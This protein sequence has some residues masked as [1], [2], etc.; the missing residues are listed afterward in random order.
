MKLDDVFA[1]GGNAFGDV[2]AAVQQ[3]EI[4]QIISFALSTVT[5][6]IIIAF[7]IWA[8]WKKAKA[9]G[10]ISKEEIDE[11]HDIIDESRKDK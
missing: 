3:N 9:D 7:K 10:K 4:L 6:V 11:L 2:L 8:W 5:S 1:I